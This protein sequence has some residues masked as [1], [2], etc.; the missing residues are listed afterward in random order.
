MSKKKR[1]RKTEITKGR[2]SGIQAVA[3]KP[4][5]LSFS[6]KYF[7]QQNKRFSVCDRDIAYWLTLLA[8]FK[9]LSGMTVQELLRSRSKAIRCHPIT[10]QDT[11][12]RCFGLPNEE[13]LV[14]TP[15]Q[16]SL[17]ANAHGRVHGFFINDVFYVVWL[18][19]EHRLYEG[20]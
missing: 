2:L 5:G 20:K 11:S 12:Q 1:I 15:Y 18:D 19:P 4:Q 10:W 14:D 7:Q 9:G 3:V 13:Q 16:F 6:F 17:S 8:R